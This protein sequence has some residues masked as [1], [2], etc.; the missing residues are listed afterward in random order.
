MDEITQVWDDL[1]SSVGVWEAV[2]VVGFSLVFSVTA[3]LMYQFFYGSRYIGAG[4]QRT[5]ILGGPAI[6]ALFLAIKTSVPLGLGMLGALAFV[7]FRT[8]VKD[9]AEIGFLLLLVASSIGTATGNFLLTGLIFAV[10]FVCLLIQWMTRNRMTFFS[11][12][13]FML[14]VEQS[15]YSN[16][17]EQLG[18]FLKERLPGLRMETMSVLEDRVS[19]QYQYRREKDFDW[20]AFTSEL[21]QIAHPAKLEIFVG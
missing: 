12:G 13:H 6:T 5:F 16:L 21:N 11:R 20:A 9:P 4:V 8:P 14:S 19:L 15:A 3:Y 18:T 17:G 2:I 7:R 1:Q 10:V